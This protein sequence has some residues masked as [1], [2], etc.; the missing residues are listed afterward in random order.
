MPPKH[1][2]M[3]QRRKLVPIQYKTNPHVSTSSK[4]TLRRAFTFAICVATTIVGVSY[5][6]REYAESTYSNDVAEL[7]NPASSVGNL[8][9]CS[10]ARTIQMHT[11]LRLFCVGFACSREDKRCLL[12]RCYNYAIL[13]LATDQSAGRPTYVGFSDIDRFWL[14]QMDLACGRAGGNCVVCTIDRDARTCF[15][16]DSSVLLAATKEDTFS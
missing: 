2:L 14:S 5:F 13:E 6:T 1:I 12:F 7:W 3:P 16:S 11:R 4:S 15:R 9:M 10:D 8:F